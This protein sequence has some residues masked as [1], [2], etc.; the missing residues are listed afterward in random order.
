LKEKT[1]AT[2]KK[3]IEKCP[4]HTEPCIF[5]EADMY[6]GLGHRTICPMGEDE[7]VLEFNSDY[8]NQVRIYNYLRKVK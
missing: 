3:Y 8:G 1:S 2:I 7:N 5:S 6:N 4:G